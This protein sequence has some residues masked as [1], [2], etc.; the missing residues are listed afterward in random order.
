MGVGLVKLNVKISKIE[1]KNPTMLASGILGETAG[2][3]KRIAR[4]GAGAVVTKSIGREPREGY[5]NP[6]CVEVECGMLNSM[7]LPN[8]GIV[9]FGKEIRELERIDIPVIGS[10]FGKNEEEFAIL[11]ERMEDYGVDGV[12]LNL[13]C[14]HA[15][16]YGLELGMSP[17]VVENIVREVKGRVSLPVFA[18]L[19]ANSGNIVDIG[20]AAEDG[21]ADGVVATNSLRAMKIDIHIKKP[22]LYNKFGGYSG[23][24]IKPVGVRCVYELS[25]E[26]DIPVIGVGGVEDWK[27]AVEY[28]LAGAYAV[29]IGSA[30]YRRGFSIFRNI[31]YG[32]KRWMEE[33]G[34]ENI[35]DFRGLA[36]R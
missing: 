20:K 11:A 3:I 30:I 12:E 31:C 36:L 8:P 33:N 2:S 1:M 28:I 35:E 10:I 29:Q 13:S 25:S 16:G 19:S 9:E 14:P 4:A 34:F 15:K 26:L 21:G 7:G 6:T 24:G 27:D 17:D 23:R 32:I 22:I 5:P 18:K